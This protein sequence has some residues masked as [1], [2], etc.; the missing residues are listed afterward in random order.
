MAVFAQQALRTVLH[1][2]I[3]LVTARNLHWCHCTPDSQCPAVT[4]TVSLASLLPLLANLADS[5]AANFPFSDRQTQ[6]CIRAKVWV[7]QNNHQI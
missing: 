1:G 3:T 5:Q 7:V 4:E 2:I 6:S